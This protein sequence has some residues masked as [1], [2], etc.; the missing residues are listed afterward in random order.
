MQ[1]ELTLE[2]TKKVEVYAKTLHLI[3]NRKAD[4]N[5]DAKNAKKMSTDDLLKSITIGSTEQ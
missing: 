5:E 2:E 4:D 1:G 3:R